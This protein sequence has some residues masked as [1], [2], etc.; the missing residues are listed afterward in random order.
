MRALRRRRDEGETLVEVL[1]A[2]AILSIVATGMLGALGSALRGA[3][4]Q[5]V[6]V[7]VESTRSSYVEALRAA[8]PYAACPALSTYAPAALGWTP[9][10]GYALRVTSVESW[11]GT[12]TSPATFNPVTASCVP[13]ADRGLQRLVVEVSTTSGPASTTTATV[14]WRRP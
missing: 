11:D 13:G 4:A 1:V 8:A 10:S 9:P 7:Q 5:D 2:T 6:L 12:S 14:L 3:H